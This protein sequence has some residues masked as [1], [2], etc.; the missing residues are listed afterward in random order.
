MSMSLNNDAFLKEVLP[1]CTELSKLESS[2]LVTDTALKDLNG[3]IGTLLKNSQFKPFLQGPAEKTLESLQKRIEEGK[4]A[5]FST[6]VNHFSKLLSQ[7]MMTQKDLKG[8]ASIAMQ[9]SDSSITDDLLYGVV[10][11]LSL[12]RLEDFKAARELIAN[13]KNESLKNIALYTYLLP[14]IYKLYEDTRQPELLTELWTAIVLITKES[15]SDQALEQKCKKC[16]A[17]AFAK[18]VG[19]FTERPE[20]QASGP[21]NAIVI[22][23][24]DPK[25]TVHADKALYQID[26]DE[27]VDPEQE[28]LSSMKHLFNAC[29]KQDAPAVIV[30]NLAL[31]MPI[32]LNE[33]IQLMLNL[34]RDYSK[35][36]DSV[37]VCKAVFQKYKEET[38]AASLEKNDFELALHLIAKFPN[39][40]AWRA[41]AL[42]KGDQAISQYLSQGNIDRAMSCCVNFS[43]H[44]DT[45]KSEDSAKTWT[46]TISKWLDAINKAREAAD[47][48]SAT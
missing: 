20:L 44:A 15:P 36:P 12:Q 41:R 35:D 37:A 23:V 4:F 21:A 8:A 2:K 40:E 28:R 34:I 6:T 27:P 30:S 46:E 26:P 33:K 1:I 7:N 24:F 13:I 47:Q 16:R 3:K 18:I 38:A 17:D 11:K 42:T 29:Y 14:A 19:Y 32:S 45:I 22:S 10:S 31:A 39:V 48:A 25:H 5:N 9:V 43:E